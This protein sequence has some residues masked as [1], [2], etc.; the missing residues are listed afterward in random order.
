MR[1]KEK[2][3]VVD[4][5]PNLRK[6]LADILRIKGYES[7]MVGSGAEAIA[8]AGQDRISLALIDLMLPDMSGLDVMTRIKALSPLTEAIVLTGHASLETA[9]EATGKGAFS[10]LLKPYQMEDL[11]LIIRH[12]MERRQAQ[13]EIQRLASYAR[14]NPN[15]VIEMDSSGNVTYLNPAAQKHFPE[16]TSSASKYPLLE[17]VDGL[18][19]AFRGDGEQEIV[20]EIALGT[21]VYEERIYYVRE[22]DLIRFYV[23]DVTARKR[24]D[25]QLRKLAQAVE[26]SPESIVITDLD[27]NIEYVNGAF[28][29]ITGYGR[30]ELI[31]RNPRILQSDKTPRENYDALWRSLSRGETWEGEF[32]NRRKDGS[33]Y[34]EFAIITP[35][36]QADG[37]I[38]HYVAVKEDITDKKH[39]SQELERLNRQ[40]ELILTSA[41]EGIYGADTE[42]I[43]NFINPAAASLLSYTRDELLG[44]DAHTTLH[45]SK[46]DGSPYR[47]AECPMQLSL[48]NGLE[49]RGVE[50]TLW[51]K[52]GSPLPVLFSSLPIMDEGAIVGAVTTFQDISELKRYQLQ[53]ERQSNYDDLTGLPNRNLLTDR[54]SQAAARCQRE[55]KKLAVL[56]FNLDRF[57]EVNDSLGRAVGDSVLRETAERMR[58]LV[59]E[60]DT[61]ARSGGDEFVLVGEVAEEEDAAYL[62]R[63]IMLTLSQ[64]FLIEGGDLSLHAGVGISVLPK[65]GWNSEILLNNAMVAMYRTKATSGNNFLFYSAEM[66]AHSLERLNMENELRRAVER[67]ELLLF[68]QPQMSLRNGEIIGMEALLRWQHPLR[69][70]VSPMEFIPLAE[71]T[72]LIV[73][74]GEW[75]LRT[76]CA[77]NQAWQAAGLPAVAVAVN[78]SARQFEGQD[79]VALTAQV[80]RET[81]LDPSYLELE[82]TESAAMGNA[83]AFIGVTEALKGLGVTLSIDDF[84]TGYSSLSYLKRFALDRLKIDQ[85]FVRDIVQNPDSAAIAVTVIAL[86]HGLGLS[87]IAEGV[88]TEA[89][90]NFLRTR[91]CDEMQGFYFSKPL[92]GA[93]FEQLLRE[94]RKLVFPAAAELPVQTLLLVDDEPSILSALKRVLRREGYQILTATSAAEGMELLATH[95]VAVVMSDQRMPHVTGAEFLAKVRV[96]YPD[97]V[98]IILSGYTELKTLTEVVNRGEIYKFLEK[99]WDEAALRETLREA[100]RH[101]EER[102]SARDDAI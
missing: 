59:R 64:P 7:V 25:E 62:A 45:H 60:T 44:K 63:R 15:P 77:Q 52:D 61:L 48:A 17:G 26:Q 70:L 92:P 5:D 8:V 39:A 40:N 65:D 4:D 88:E 56:V 33:E 96:M 98:R 81:G 29:R 58:H 6:T 46:P 66:N 57:K 74:I 49:I 42:G 95:Q 79:M 71:E 89:Q 12:A 23:L 87:V 51:R 69:G 37:R 30:E 21:A 85:S 78:L 1:A 18:F 34:T 11:L 68:Y 9:I 27:A 31:G 93:E 53:L 35:I 101:Y 50:E 28:L 83:E 97:T 82:L 47:R 13:E 86:A 91:G 80:L 22:S 67:N 3:L 73:P 19:A 38:S 75:V 41:W 84:G 55:Q 20:R 54:L 99:P 90:L 32:I 43:I 94:R 24:A 76:A 72:G 14:L 10:Y 36:R 16:L 102:R 100:F 2:L